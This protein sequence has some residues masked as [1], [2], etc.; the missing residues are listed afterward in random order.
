M[1]DTGIV[2]VQYRCKECGMNFGDPDL[3]AKGQLFEK[4]CQGIRSHTHFSHRGDI[5]LPV[6]DLIEPL[7]LWTVQSDRADSARDID[8]IVGGLPVWPRMV[9]TVTPLTTWGDRAAALGPR[10]ERLK[11][12]QEYK[13]PGDAAKRSGDSR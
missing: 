13:M 7:Y 1:N 8:D 11:A 3:I 5:A 12:A 6:N 10:L 4:W 2:S 9:T